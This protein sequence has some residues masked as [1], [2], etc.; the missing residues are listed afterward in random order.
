MNEEPCIICGRDA[1]CT[2]VSGQAE[3]C[4]YRCDNC[5]K[6]IFRNDLNKDDYEDLDGEQRERIANYVREFNKTSGG[7]WAE[8]GDI[9]EL[10][11]KIE[12]FNRTRQQEQ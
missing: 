1:L 2:A 12:D 6:Y 9:E 4:D 5:G 3:T 11:K 10:W 7:K 8:F